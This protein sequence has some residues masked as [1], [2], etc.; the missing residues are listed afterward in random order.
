MNEAFEKAGL[1][2]TKE[3]MVVL[4]KLDE[5]DGLNQNELAF[6]TYRNKSSLTRLLVKMES[7]AYIE[8]RQGKEDKRVNR[9]FLTDTGRAVYRK[10][11]PV[12]KSL[13]TTM[14]QHIS[15]ADKAQMI[16]LL[17]QVQKN[18]EPALDF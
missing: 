9:V 8:R 13:I 1:D 6:L 7:K 4:K 15:E 17:K 11:R 5:Q 16:M 2:L 10:T 18:F 14:E 3:Q 12:I